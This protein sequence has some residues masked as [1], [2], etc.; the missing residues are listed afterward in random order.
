MVKY[1]LMKYGGDAG[2]VY[3]MGG[4]SGAML[5]QAMLAV[6]PDLFRAGAARAGVPA[7]CWA[8]SYDPSPSQEW[9]GPCAGGT[10]S[11]TAMEWA[12]WCGRW[13]PATPVI[14]RAFS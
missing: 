1:A 5:T 14:A 2:R 8:V 4:S 6:Y 3:I 9:S 10:V 7:G 12:T 11:H 13:I